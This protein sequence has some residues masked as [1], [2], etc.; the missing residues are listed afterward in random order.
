MRAALAVRVTL[1]TAPPRLR[2]LQVKASQ[3]NP[4]HTLPSCRVGVKVTA[5]LVVLAAGAR[6]GGAADRL[7]LLGSAPDLLLLVALLLL[8]LL[9]EVGC[10][11]LVT[12]ATRCMHSTCCRMARR[13]PHSATMAPSFFSTRL[14]V[15]SVGGAGQEL[16]RQHVHERNHRACGVV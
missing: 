1:I 3:G 5:Q 14:E 8:L 16:G 13:W 2:P 9:L 4:G 15:S 11:G 6:G 12:T 10:K 7:A